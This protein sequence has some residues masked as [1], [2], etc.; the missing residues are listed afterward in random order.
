MQRKGNLKFHA[1]TYVV[2]RESNVLTMWR[3]CS[4]AEQRDP[5]SKCLFFPF[6]QCCTPHIANAYIRIVQ[7]WRITQ[8]KYRRSSC[9]TK[10]RLEVDFFHIRNLPSLSLVKERVLSF[11]Y[12]PVE[13]VQFKW[14]HEEK[15]IQFKVFG[16]AKA[17][18]S[19]HIPELELPTIDCM[20]S[21]TLRSVA[22]WY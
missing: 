11:N 12:F 9:L 18:D 8:S 21:L 7:W 1:A 4:T 16:K 10:F 14:V 19:W 5:R 17:A 22:S 15:K 3:L 2:E 6:M 20:F 13:T